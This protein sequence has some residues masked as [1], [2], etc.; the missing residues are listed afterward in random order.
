MLP[1][2]DVVK[3]AHRL[4]AWAWGSSPSPPETADSIRRAAPILVDWLH[5]ASPSEPSPSHVRIQGLLQSAFEN[6]TVSEIYG[7]SNADTDIALSIMLN[8]RVC[9]PYPKNRS[10]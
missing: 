9:N 6:G 4:V 7:L 5:R 3:Q 8:V 2:W 1:Y 10:H